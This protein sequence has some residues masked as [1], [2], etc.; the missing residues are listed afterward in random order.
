MDILAVFQ[1]QAPLS[2]RNDVPFFRI[3]VGPLLL[4]LDARVR[5]FHSDQMIRR[6]PCRG[7]CK[8]QGAASIKSVGRIA[9]V[10]CYQICVLLG[11]QSFCL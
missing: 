8:F 10:F 2:Y 6:S 7:V 1:K 5:E 11:F 3:R 4:G 9:E